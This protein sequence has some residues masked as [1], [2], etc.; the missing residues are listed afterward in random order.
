[1]HSNLSMEIWRQVFIDFGYSGPWAKLR[2]F[3]CGDYCD[4]LGHLSEP[5]SSN[6]I[7][8]KHPIN[9]PNCVEIH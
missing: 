7:N 6:P 1:M 8:M 2:S 3:D 5:H 4:K 9:G